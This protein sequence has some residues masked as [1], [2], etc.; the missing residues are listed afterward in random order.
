MAF[1]ATVDGSTAGGSES[2]SG[3]LSTSGTKVVGPLAE[4]ASLTLV[5]NGPLGKD[6]QTV[7]VAVT[8]SGSGA[9]PTKK[10]GGGVI[11]PFL[12]AGLLL[13]WVSIRRAPVTRVRYRR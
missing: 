9:S 3:S 13:L 1:A 11:D 5:C 8:E 10:V 7:A 12:T 6:Q 2:W 4:S